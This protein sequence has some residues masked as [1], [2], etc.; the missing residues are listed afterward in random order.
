MTSTNKNL[1]KPTVRDTCPKCGR[2]S[3]KIEIGN[4]GICP[5]CGFMWWPQIP[6]AL[7]T[8]FNHNCQP[9]A[10]A[11]Y[12]KLWNVTEI[13][14]ELGALDKDRGID[15]RIIL[16]N[17]LTLDIQEKFRRPHQRKYWQF[18]IEYKNNPQTNEPGEF[19]HLAAN[20]YF[21]SYTFSPNGGIFTDWWI[22]CLNKFKDYYNRNLLKE[23]LGGRNTKRS[24]TT[25]KCFN[26]DDLNKIIYAQN[27]D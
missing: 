20:Y 18:T 19:Y 11:I 1:N 13:E 10:D 4:K 14:R 9:Y 25:F 24:H 6:Y 8:I 17:G 7:D 21:Y 23:A 16:N 5:G 15:C 22:I 26:F 2:F 3:I 12:K 27:G